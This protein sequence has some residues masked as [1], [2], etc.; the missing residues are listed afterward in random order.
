MV[1]R[2]RDTIWAWAT[3]P[4][5]AAI[6]VLRIS[7]PDAGAALRALTG[8][9][10]PP[11][12]RA[13]L[14]TLRDPRSG[15]P[16]DRGL[17]VWF[18]APR[19]YTG[20]DMV[21]LHHHAGTAVARALA[22]AL[23][24]V[25]GLRPAGPGEFTRRAFLNGK[26]DL[27]AAEAVADIIGATTR[28]QLRQALRQSEG[29]LG[30]ACAHWRERLLEASALLEAE[31]DFADEEADVGHGQR[32][33]IRP[34]VADVRDEILAALATAER[35]ERLREGLVV[36]VVGAPNV[37]KSSLVNRLAGRE[38]AIVTAVPGTTRDPIE[39]AL[40]LGGVPV[41]LVDTAGLRDTDDPVEREGVARAR[42]RAGAAD[43]CLLVVDASRPELVPELATEPEDR[44]VVV[45]KIDLAPLPE[46]F[47]GRGDV[48]AVSCR[49]GAGLDALVERLALCAAER[50]AG[51]ES[52]LVTR[53]RHRQALEEAAAALDRF[54]EAPEAVEP[55]L[56]AEELRFAT[57]AIGR[58]SGQVDVEELLDRIFARF[59]IGK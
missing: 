30:R 40:E 13:T 2:V 15:E 17:V 14:R 43:L 8:R 28:A 37:G 21:E 4:G 25:P 24:A 39:V 18:P 32:E 35:G 48:I 51:G 31:L 38:V 56:L 27:A 59:C 36:A 54:L 5:R 23:A 19:S 55:V 44:L 50:C 6:A 7:G 47:S 45:N 9:P 11:E 20:E 10:P 33:R 53:A 41:T 3:A 57:A 42:A 46:A 29:A 52:A 26:L 22:E 58:V 12:R 16:I 49:T 1:G 34:L